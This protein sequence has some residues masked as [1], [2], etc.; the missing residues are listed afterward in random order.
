WGSNGIITSSHIQI[1]Q[2]WVNNYGTSLQSYSFQSYVHEIG[3]A[4]GLGHGGEYN[5]TA[6]YS[7]DALFA[8]DSWSTTIMSYFDQQENTYF[9]NQG[10]SRLFALTPMDADV[11]AMQSLYG[12]STTTRTGDTV[13]GDNAN[14][15]GV[16]DAVAYPRAEFTI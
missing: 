2:S 14:A 12:L 1:S 10:F 15:N 7:T 5:D 8:N 6:T 9:S 3:H 13:Y 16:Y 11:L 4:L